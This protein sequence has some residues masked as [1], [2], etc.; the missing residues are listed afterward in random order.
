MARR[1]QK[2]WGSE[3]ADILVQ[4]AGAL[5]DLTPE[6]W[7]TPSMC[8][9]WRVRDAAGHIVYRIGTST[10]RMLT[11]GSAAYFGKHLNPM[12]AL[13]DLGA[14]ASKAEP[15]ELVSQIRHIA[16]L[17]LGG[18]G[19]T[20]IG[21]LTE[22]VVHSYDITRPLGIALEIE[23][24]VSEAVVRAR[25]LLLPPSLRGVTKRRTLHATDAGWRIGTGPDIE[26]TA[27]GITLFLFGRKPLPP[28]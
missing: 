16:A 10:S 22:A 26:G 3:I 21:E 17:K 14:E 11:T 27:Q 1:R 13:D 5:D 4:L 12:R 20:G 9:G 24:R 23:P 8:E 2:H 25:L 7:E 18:Q 15:A 6:Q 19:R 28:T